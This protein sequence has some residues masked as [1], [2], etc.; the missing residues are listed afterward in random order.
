ME[1]KTRGG[2]VIAGSVIGFLGFVLPSLY[3][4]TYEPPPGSPLAHVVLTGLKDFGGGVGGGNFAVFNGFAGP[5]NFHPTL[6]SLIALTLIGIVGLNWNIDNATLIA[7]VAGYSVSAV[8]ML[9]PIAQFIW[10][11][12]YDRTPATI[13]DVFVA[14]LGGGQNAVTAAQYVHG[15]LGLGTLILAFGLLVAGVGV[16]PIVGWPLLGVTVTGFVVLVA[17]SS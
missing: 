4:A 7:K 9:W 2:F 12:R 3:G 16:K 13:R 17:V 1:S 11:F 5:V 15:E 14:D 8:A 6:Y 10:E